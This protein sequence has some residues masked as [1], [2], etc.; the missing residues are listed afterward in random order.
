MKMSSG[1]PRPLASSILPPLILSKPLLSYAAFHVQSQVQKTM[2]V[3]GRMGNPVSNG[4][5]AQLWMSC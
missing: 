3:M 5:H 1:I 4:R 2:T